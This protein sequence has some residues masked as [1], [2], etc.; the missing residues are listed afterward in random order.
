MKDILNQMESLSCH[1]VVI[2]NDLC[3]KRTVVNAIGKVAAFHN[4]FLHS[5]KLGQG[6]VR[7]DKAGMYLSE[8]LFANN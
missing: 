3:L 6:G 7:I 1:L 4:I 2:K 5:S 8:Q